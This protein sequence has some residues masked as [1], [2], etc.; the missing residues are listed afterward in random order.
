MCP[1]QAVIVDPPKDGKMDGKANGTGTL[2]IVTLLKVLSFYCVK[3]S[4]RS[5]RT[6]IKQYERQISV[7]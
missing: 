4:N 1:M 7:I 6:L 5:F 3:L 2:S